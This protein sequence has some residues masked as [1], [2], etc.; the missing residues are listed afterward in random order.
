MASR[1][2]LGAIFIVTSIHWGKFIGTKI[3]FIFYRQ[4]NIVSYKTV[5]EDYGVPYISDHYPVL[6]KFKY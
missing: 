4:A 5:V 2:D 3:V 1:L 6:S